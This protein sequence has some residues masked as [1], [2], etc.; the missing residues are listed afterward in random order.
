M[1]CAL[2]FDRTWFAATRC[3]LAELVVHKG[4]MFR[5]PFFGITRFS[6]DWACVFSVCTMVFIPRGDRGN[7][8]QSS[9]ELFG[10]QEHGIWRPKDGFLSEPRDLN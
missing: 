6:A 8:S 5:V 9:H 4:A 7:T 2:G 10:D 1:V 3:R